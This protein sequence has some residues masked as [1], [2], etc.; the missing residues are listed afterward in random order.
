MCAL[1]VDTY[2]YVKHYERNVCGKVVMA[3][4]EL[5]KHNLASAPRQTHRIIIFQWLQSASN[6][7]VA[8][9]SHCNTGITH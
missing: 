3:Q 5:T 7:N 4:S 1:P 8:A 9:Q 6:C 2:K